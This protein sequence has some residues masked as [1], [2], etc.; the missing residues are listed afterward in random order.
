M[1]A[2][3]R[4]GVALVVG[5]G[6][7]GFGTAALTGLTFAQLP[8]SVPL[9]MGVGLFLADTTVVELVPTLRVV[10]AI[11]LAAY[12]CFYLIAVCLAGITAAYATQRF[13]LPLQDQFFVAA[14]RALGFDWFAITH[15]V[16]DHPLAH[17][18]LRFAYDTMSI[19]IVLPVMI[20]ALLDRD[21]AL[22]RYLLAFAISL[23][24][25][26]AVGAL[27]PAASPIAT[28]DLSAFHVLQFTGATPLDHLWLLRSAGPA[29]MTGGS[30]LGGIITFPSFHAT[31]AVLTPLA[32][33]RERVVFYPLVL[34]DAFML[35]SAVTEGA[36]YVSDVLAGAAVALL[37]LW[38][39]GKLTSR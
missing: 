9:T 8:T 29:T 34:L 5:L 36:H 15:W 16:D 27:L 13:G 24:V 12:G 30:G 31:C 35:C 14:D 39:A 11:R 17:T 26:I 1:S 22:R 3:T 10:R 21:A 23:A 19:Q 7:A 4:E 38:L 33:R 25:T 20:L 6:M 18:V 37:A 28:L 2:I 32:L